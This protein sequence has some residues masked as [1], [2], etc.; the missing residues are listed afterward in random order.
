LGL[1]HQHN[2]IMKRYIAE[3]IGT[4]FLVLTVVLTNGQPLAPLAIGAILIG[5]SYGSTAISG[6]HFNPAVSLAALVRRSINSSEFPLYVIA[7]LLGAI[8]AS[9]LGAYL[10]GANG[11]PAPSPRSIET[12]STLMAE[13]VGT[14]ALVYAGLRAANSTIASSFQ[15][16]PWASGLVFAAMIWALGPISGGLFNPAIAVGTAISQLTAWSDLLIYLI[17]TCMGAAAAATV[18]GWIE[19]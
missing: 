16:T 15:T 11:V 7:Q 3:G 9:L 14:F 4:F 12:M 19:E 17:G 6:A 8:I 2:E 10:Q 18:L 13:F 1:H 5:M